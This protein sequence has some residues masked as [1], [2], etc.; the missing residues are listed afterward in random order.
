MIARLF[1]LSENKHC[2]Q[3]PHA[4][5]WSG[6][7]RESCRR[8]TFGL[9]IE[10]KCYPSRGKLTP[11]PLRTFAR[12]CCPLCSRLCHPFCTN[13]KFCHAWNCESISSFFCCCCFSSLWGLGEARRA[14]S[15][16]KSAHKS[17]FPRVLLVSDVDVFFF[18]LLVSSSPPTQ[19]FFP[20][21]QKVQIGLRVVLLTR[22]A[23]A[24]GALLVREKPRRFV[25]FNPCK[26][27]PH[28]VFCSVCRSTSLHHPPP[29]VQ[30]HISQQHLF[31]HQCSSLRFSNQQRGA[32]P[33]HGGTS[34]AV[35]TG[36][37][38]ALL[39]FF[40]WLNFNL[41]SHA[42]PPLSL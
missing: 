34:S 30:T 3:R 5:T 14:M 32:F 25:T 26:P 21:T 4:L 20:Q 40:P 10:M 38:V 18:L 11:T 13:K 29:H 42:P 31:L 2:L 19:N 17:A 41:L 37:S 22:L 23:H 16:S 36:C 35:G 15:S 6:I 7:N 33:E 39:A 9:F 24:F 27:C 28:I 12:R 1:K 8:P